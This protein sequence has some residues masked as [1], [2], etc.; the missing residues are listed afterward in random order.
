M[1]VKIMTQV[2]IKNTQCLRHDFFFTFKN[3]KECKNIYKIGVKNSA[4]YLNRVLKILVLLF[5]NWEP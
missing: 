5:L 3:K 2:E 4:K 1:N